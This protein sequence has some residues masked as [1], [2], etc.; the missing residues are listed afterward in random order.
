VYFENAG[1]DIAVIFFGNGNR[2][3]I[4]IYDGT[5]QQER[6]LD[7][8]DVDSVEVEP[9]GTRGAAPKVVVH[10]T[11][12]SWNGR[13]S[14]HLER[15]FVRNA[16]QFDFDDITPDEVV[17][18][19]VVHWEPPVRT[20]NDPNLI[21]AYAENIRSNRT[22]V[23]KIRIGTQRLLLPS[24]IK[25]AATGIVLQRRSL[26]SIAV[27]GFHVIIPNAGVQDRYCAKLGGHAIR[28]CD[29]SG[30]CPAEGQI[31]IGEKAP[32]WITIQL[33]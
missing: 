22:S 14:T 8:H 23:F 20:C 16:Q 10:S 4:I 19:S 31:E 28:I 17:S 21:V 6:S 5:A 27:D 33:E 3:K 13:P 15:H 1:C 11:N 25:D 12:P 2:R 29:I 24:Y 32:T 26:L 7:L 18:R 30:Q 9:S